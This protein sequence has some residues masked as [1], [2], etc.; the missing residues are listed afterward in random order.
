MRI[1][2]IS[3]FDVGEILRRRGLGQSNEAQRFLASEVARLSD[4]YVPMQQG[5]LKAPV[6]FDDKIVYSSPYAHYQYHGE[7]MVG[8][9]TKSAWAKSGEPKE[10]TGRPINYH[11][12]PMRGKEWDKRMMAER[13]RE[14]EESLAAYIRSRGI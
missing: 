11:G 7:V 6:L 2:V 9:H 8:K 12:G 5:I 3:N 4:P 10:Y 14:L 1:N 13:G